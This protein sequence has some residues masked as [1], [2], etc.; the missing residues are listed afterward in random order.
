MKQRDGTTKQS[1]K[2]SI[3]KKRTQGDFNRVISSIDLLDTFAR[4]IDAAGARTESAKKDLMKGMKALW[5]EVLSEGSW[6]EA[7]SAIITI[8]K[9]PFEARDKPKARPERRRQ[10][11]AG[12]HHPYHGGQPPS[13]SGYFPTTWQQVPSVGPPAQ[14]QHPGFAPAAQ[15]TFNAHQQQLWA[16][17]NHGQQQQHPQQQWHRSSRPS[18]TFC[19][20]NGHSEASCWSKHPDKRPGKSS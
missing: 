7:K 14:P 20:V 19:N 9:D 5:K 3:A 8:G 10:R 2:L 1:N 4:E 15:G 13:S 12:P 6:T 18:C 16:G 17:A 11:D